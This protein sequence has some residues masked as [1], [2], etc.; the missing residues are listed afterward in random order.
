M[1]FILILLFKQHRERVPDLV[2]AFKRSLPVGC[3][4]VRPGIETFT[5]PPDHCTTIRTPGFVVEDPYG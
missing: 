1:A 3:A 4:K 2:V 5:A